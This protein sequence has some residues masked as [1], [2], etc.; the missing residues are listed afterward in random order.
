MT[1]NSRKVFEFLKK[2]KDKELTKY[3]IVEELDV[4]ISAVTGC[5]NN[6]VK[7]KFAEER[8]EILMPLHQGQKPSTI[9]W[10]KLT[11]LGL[12]YDPDEE[13]R[14]IAREKLEAKALRKAERL[15]Q[16]EER[17]RQNAVL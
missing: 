14:R 2:N 5:I 13:E 8:M 16:R 6:L 3:E 9:R 17:A 11:E 12:A 15:A 1:E 10:V 7:K 4:P